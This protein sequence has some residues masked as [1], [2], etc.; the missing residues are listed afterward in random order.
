LIGRKS[1]Y[2]GRCRSN[3]APPVAPAAGAAM[4]ESDRSGRSALHPSQ[5]SA[6]DG[7]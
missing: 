1:K 3:G 4:V 2:L 7:E 5:D 6:D